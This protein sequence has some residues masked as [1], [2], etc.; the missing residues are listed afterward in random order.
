MG[1]QGGGADCITT[2]FIVFILPDSSLGLIKN[3]ETGRAYG[4]VGGE[5]K[6]IQSFG[7]KTRGTKTIWK[8]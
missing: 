1:Q 7:G 8:T 5:D 6:L 2:I 3:G 4:T